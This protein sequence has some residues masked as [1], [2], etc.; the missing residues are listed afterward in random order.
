MRG[1]RRRGGEDWGRLLHALESIRSVYDPLNAVMGLG[2]D[3][4]VRVRAVRAAAR[5]LGGGGVRVADLGSG[6]GTSALAVLEVL[7][8]SYLVLLDPSRP[9]L[10][11]NK[12]YA[13]H[14]E[15]C[16]R[17]EAV[18][19]AVPLRSRAVD[20]AASF[21]VLRDVVDLEES[22]RESF[23]VARTVL[24][25]DIF[26]PPRK[27]QRVA[28]YAWFCIFVTLVG[29][30]AG[31]PG[32]YMELCRTLLHWHSV[33]ELSPLCPGRVFEARLD[34]VGFTYALLC[35]SETQKS[36]VSQTVTLDTR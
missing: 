16:E 29:G 21:F 31:K 30:L 1:L 4:G 9:L 2:M 5:M 23:R 8:P 32:G 7:T 33:W 3:F 15:L 35:L 12:A 19:E 36:G 11:S 28:M 13:A 26:K 14:P 20:L 24:H 22:L 25:V 27:A 34:P 18:M 17:V 6:P 10:S